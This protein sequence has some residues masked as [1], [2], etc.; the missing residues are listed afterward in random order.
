M[1]DRLALPLLILALACPVFAQEEAKENGVPVLKRASQPAPTPVPPA[2]D[3]KDKAPLESEGARLE[4]WEKSLNLTAQ[5]LAE[6]QRAIAEREAALADKER[7]LA[8][9]QTALDARN[10]AL[11]LRE[12]LVRV[13]AKPKVEDTAKL[14]TA[15]PVTAWKGGKAPTIVAKSAFV[16]DAKNGRILHEKDGRATAP[17]AEVQLLMTAL[18]IA[19]AGDLEM[20]VPI[21]NSDLEG[22]GEKIGMKSGESYPRSHLLKWMLLQ[23]AQDAVNALVRDHAGSADAFV[24][25]MNSRAKALGMTSTVFT[26]PDGKAEEGQHST[27]RD[28]AL[29]AWE[30]YSHPFLRECGS[31]KTFALTLKSGKKVTATNKNELMRTEKECNGL[32]MGDSLGS[33]YCLAASGEQDGRE[34]IVVV[35]GSTEAWIWKDSKVLLEWALSSD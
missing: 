24:V 14:P 3:P 2:P 6:R 16:L 21:L 31:T 29:L 33:R 15:A 19:E 34:R 27:A 10:A 4:A 20:P 8:S 25:K 1:P 28:V 30:C 5:S 26:D 9:R 11:E 12:K 17:I 23:P 22:E 7:A 32:M 18:L 13:P 35:L